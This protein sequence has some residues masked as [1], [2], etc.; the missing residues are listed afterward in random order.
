V[1]GDVHNGLVAGAGLRQLHDESVPVVV[2][3]PSLSPIERGEKAS[4]APKSIAFPHNPRHRYKG[5]TI[6]QQVA[7][8]I[9][10]TL[11]LSAIRILERDT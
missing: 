7:E 1:T 4:L 2:P 9:V 6:Q 3:I 11:S 10:Y 5:M 8:L